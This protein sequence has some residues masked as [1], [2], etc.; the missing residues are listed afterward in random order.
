MSEKTRYFNPNYGVRP[1]PHWEMA[2]LISPDEI[3]DPIQRAV[4]SKLANMAENIRDSLHHTEPH[5]PVH[6][7][8]VRD[9]RGEVVDSY[10]RTLQDR[11]SV[12]QRLC[13]EVMEGYGWNSTH[14]IQKPPSLDG[15]YLTESKD[16]PSTSIQG[17]V[18]NWSAFID[19]TTHKKTEMWVAFDRAPIPQVIDA[20]TGEAFVF[21]PKRS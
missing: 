17:L 9:N 11:A 6:L 21:V 8:S 10:L 14:F 13:Q 4:D 16:Y 3:N 18:F 2:H 19:Q 7:F 15:G 5:R 12:V 1:Q 20:L